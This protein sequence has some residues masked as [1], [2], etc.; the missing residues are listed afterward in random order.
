M[1]GGQL[2]NAGGEISIAEQKGVGVTLE[3]RDSA[4]R[5]IQTI[6]GK[7]IPGHG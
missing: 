7:A 1:N 5:L 6:I 2:K 3:T 4:K